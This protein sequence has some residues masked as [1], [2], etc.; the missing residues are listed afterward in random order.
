MERITDERMDIAIGNIE[1]SIR[2]QAIGLAGRVD[3]ALAREVVG[4]PEWAAGMEVVKAAVRNL[5]RNAVMGVIFDSP[6]GVK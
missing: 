1:Q 6:G 3:P 5:I 4:T 2:S